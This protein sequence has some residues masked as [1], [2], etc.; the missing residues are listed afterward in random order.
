M[1]RSNKNFPFALESLLAVFRHAVAQMDDA[2]R[3]K[4]E[5]RGFDTR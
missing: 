3:Y 5:D 4:L 2:L 1:E